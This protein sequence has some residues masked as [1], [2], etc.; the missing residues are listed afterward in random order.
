MG[1]TILLAT[2]LAFSSAVFAALKY[3]A[4]PDKVP[5]WWDFSGNPSL[6]VP[7]WLG[8]FLLPVL[9]LLIPFIVCFFVV[10]DK[11]LG[12]QGG[13]SKHAATHIIVLPALFLFFVQNFSLLDAATSSSHDFHPRVLTA[14]ISIWLLIWLGYNLQYVEPNH[15]IGI[16]TPWTLASKTNWQKTHAHAGW[17]FPIFGIVLLVVSVVAQL[18]IGFFIGTLILWLVPYAYI[19]IY[20]S[21]LSRDE[22]SEPLL[23]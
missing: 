21:L 9:Q 7:K 13:G 6:W 10:R 22:L 17:V 3:A 11:E 16:L 1:S 23:G 2:L 12:R 20:S 18:G 14:S 5:L 15:T 19:F 8:L 4:T